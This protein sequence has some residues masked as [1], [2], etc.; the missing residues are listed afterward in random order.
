MS[1]LRSERFSAIL[2]V[3]AAVVGLLL[4]NTAA[5]PA[6]KA[7]ESFHFGIPAL[8]LDLSVGHWIKDGL[9][10]IFFFIASIDLTHEL[11][12]T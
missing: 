1:L 9:L 4:A 6:A 3:A 10:A 11:R 2:L 12:H 8:G 5:A 7:V